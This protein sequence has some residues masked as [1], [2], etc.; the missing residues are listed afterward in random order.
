MPKIEIYTTPTCPYCVK[1]KKLLDSKEVQY[2]EINVDTDEVKYQEM[3]KRSGR[4]TVPEI[5][6][7]GKFIG[8]CDDLCALE[9]EGKLDPLLK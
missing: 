7:D 6:I 2:E 9:K 5:F 1:A 3:I 4:K 8:G